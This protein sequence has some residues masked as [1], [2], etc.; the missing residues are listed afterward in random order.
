MAKN[1]SLYW[2]P[3]AKANTFPERKTGLEPATYSLGSAAAD[4]Q[5]SYFRLFSKYFDLYPLGIRRG[6][7]PGELLPLVFEIF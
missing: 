1:K 6:G 7:L 5:V 4:N 2:W 3:E